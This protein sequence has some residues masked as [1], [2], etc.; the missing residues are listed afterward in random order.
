MKKNDAVLAVLLVIVWGFNFTVI[1]IGLGGVPS[2]LLVAL[3]YVFTVFPAIFFVKKPDTEWKYIILYG[4]F[5]G[6][7]QFACLF[8]AIEIGMPTGISSIVLQIQAFISPVLAMLFLN[9]KMKAKQVA[10][11]FVA[12]AGL[13]LI[14]WA[15]TGSGVTSIP[16]AAIFL[17]ILAPFFWAA[18]NIVARIASD[19]S[20]AQGKKLNMFS[21]VVWSGLIPPIPMLI[22][23]ML[24]NSP[25]EL[26]NIVLNL[27]STSIFA[28]IYLACGATLFGYGIWNVLLGKY[29]M[30]KVAPLPL[31]VPAVSL[32]SSMLVLKEQLSAMQWIGVA[33]IFA[34]VLIT[35][36]NLNEIFKRTVKTP[37]EE[38]SQ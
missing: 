29:P 12:T 5:V 15:N 34:G 4:L 27:S 2:M 31:M 32:L 25:H 9:E 33:V 30:G 37:T 1:K 18:S 10:G 17:N 8:Y 35:N 24:L 3:R 6:V 20:A 21:M 16:L 28:I 23:A 22:I 36:L 38:T 14:A 7:G 19:K 11:I 13:A 26:L